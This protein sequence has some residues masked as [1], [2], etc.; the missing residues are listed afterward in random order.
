MNKLLTAALLSAMLATPAIADTT[1]VGFIY[2]GPVGDF[3]WTAG[4]DRARA[5]MKEHFGDAVET[6]IVENV[7]YGA[8]AERVMTQMAI[9]GTDVIFAASFGYGPDVNAVA[10]RFPDVAFQHA[11]GYIQD[12]PN[13][14]LYDAR[15]YEGRAVLGH[16]AGKMTETNTIGYIASY[17]IPAVIS[18]INSA[19]L[20]AK[21]VNPDVEFRIIW[22][23]S[24]FD[25]ALEADAAETLIEQGADV[26]MQHTDSTAAVR[27]AEDAGV[28]A[29]GQA[30]NML[31]FGP[32]AHL[33]AI[34]DRW[35]PYYI[36]RVQAVIDGTWEAQNSWLGFAD[37]IIEMAPWN[38]RIPAELQAEADALVAA[39]AAGEYHPF[40]GPI[41]KQDGSVWLA[42]GEVADDGSI[43]TMQFYVEGITGAIPN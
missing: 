25:P 31:E 9:S 20:H 4:H 10:G 34:V 43:A 30:S 24:W 6:T 15:F 42:D 17:P 36:D 2:I 28:M 8:D 35:S 19:Y 27:V 22:T 5:E 33:S 37:G 3:G 21:A 26:I 1:K 11:T 32:N 38:D 13:V 41:N 29:F 23:Y 14:S 7:N 39:I 16:I 40:T 18:G 12:H